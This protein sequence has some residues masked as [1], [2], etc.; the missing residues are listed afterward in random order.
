MPSKSYLTIFLVLSIQLTAKGAY[1]PP[2][3][4]QSNT[5]LVKDLVAKSKS[6][7]DVLINIKKDFER[8][9]SNCII[10]TQ[11]KNDKVENIDQCLSELQKLKPRIYDLNSKA[12]R[13]SFEYADPQMNHFRQVRQIALSQYENRSKIIQLIKSDV[14]A[15]LEKLVNVKIKLLQSQLKYSIAKGEQRATLLAICEGFQSL[16]FRLNL[17]LY[18]A[19][20]VINYGKIQLSIIQIDRVLKDYAFFENNCPP[21]TIKEDL[22]NLKAQFKQRQQTTTKEEWIEKVCKSKNLNQY[23]QEICSSKKFDS[24]YALTLLSEVKL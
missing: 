17:R 11:L 14:D 10:E 6:N 19:Q 22:L 21:S 3:S 18:E 5:N 1:G 23:A 24:D 2:S 12:R 9:K 15:V 13:L 16:K 7:D 8:I 4:L 20:R